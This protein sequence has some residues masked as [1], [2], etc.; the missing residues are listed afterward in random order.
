[1]PQRLPHNQEKDFPQRID[2]PP[3]LP[4]IFQRRKMINQ[5]ER[6]AG[7]AHQGLRFV[8]AS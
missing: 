8:E 3:T 6:R 7:F 2:D 1:M 4:G 5:A